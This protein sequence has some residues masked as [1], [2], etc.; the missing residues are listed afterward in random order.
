MKTYKGYRAYGGV[1]RVTV[2]SDSG[3]VSV[4]DPGPSQRLRNHSPDGFNWGYG[5]SGPAQLA[6]AL[7]LEHFDGDAARALSMYQD[8]KFKVIGR[9]DQDSDWSLTSDDITLAVTSITELRARTKG[10]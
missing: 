6:L 7:L 4:L 1:G 3:V 8:F 9:L 2:T 5:G 10:A